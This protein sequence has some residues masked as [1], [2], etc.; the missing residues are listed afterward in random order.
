MEIKKFKLIS[1]VRSSVLTKYVFSFK[2]MSGF[3]GGY[4]ISYSYDNVVFTHGEYRPDLALKSSGRDEA[5]SIFTYSIDDTVFFD[6]D[7]SNDVLIPGKAIYFKMTAFSTDRKRILYSDVIKTYT[8]PEVASGSNTYLDVIHGEKSISISW[9]DL[10]YTSPKHEDIHKIE[11]LKFSTSALKIKSLTGSTIYS[12]D[13]IASKYYLVHDYVYNS[14]WQVIAS[15]DGSISLSSNLI[16]D[17]SHVYTVDNPVSLY[18][19]KLYT[20]DPDGITIGSVSPSKISGLIMSVSDFTICHNSIIV[21]GVKYVMPDDETHSISYYPVFHREL[22]KAVP[23]WRTL[24]KSNTPLL[25]SLTWKRLKSVLID[26]NYY[27][28]DYWAIPYSENKFSLIGYIGINDCLVDIFINDT[29][30]TTVTSNKFGEFEFKYRFGIETTKLTVQVRSQNNE[31][32]TIF[33][34]PIFIQAYHIYTHFAVLSTQYNSIRASQ[35]EIKNKLSIDTCTV[36]DLRDIYAPR[37][38]IDLVG[39]EDVSTFRKFIKLSNLMY[40][41][42][43]YKIAYDQLKSMFETLVPGIDSVQCIDNAELEEAYTT[44]IDMVIHQFNMDGAISPIVRKKYVYGVSAKR[45]SKSGTIE[46]TDPTEIIVDNR[47]MPD[48]EY[49]HPINILSWSKVD[50]ASSYVIYKGVCDD[51]SNLNRLLF[52]KVFETTS[53]FYVDAG[54]IPQDLNVT[55]IPYNSTVMVSP[56]NVKSL[57]HL[58][59]G[60]YENL[61]KKP[62]YFTIIVYM[63]G[64]E[65][66]PQYILDRLIYLLNIITPSEQFFS[67]IVANNLGTQIYNKK[68]IRLN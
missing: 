47:W 16:Q 49:Y 64:D 24:E 3:L 28:K 65:V 5:A 66:L 14:F 39:N 17:V 53:T 1:Q 52:T 12:E 22:S 62:Y 63:K 61:L 35:I 30:Y 18:N 25:K 7:L 23:V 15:E 38:G 67:V 43:G 26:K 51:N 9:K 60:S 46:E 11:V 41:N 8:V 31:V 48:Y 20:I 58:T 2:K 29:L 56:K 21:Y 40:Q 36:Q 32:F 13:I 55:P 44:G 34:S 57:N 50:Y 59:P 27:N 19:I 45:I 37:I 42:I 10:E 6:M 33:S 4:E 68:G 54:V